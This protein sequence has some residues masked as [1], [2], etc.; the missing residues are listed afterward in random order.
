MRGERPHRH[1]PR[2]DFHQQVPRRRHATPESVLLQTVTG[3]FVDDDIYYDLLDEAD[4]DMVCK[5][6]PNAIFLVPWALEPTAMVIHDTFDKVNPIE[7]SLRNV[8]KRVLALR[9]H[10]GRLEPGGGAGD[11]V[12][13]DQAQQRPDFPLEAPWAV[14]AARKAA[15]RASPSMPPTNSTRCSRTSTTGAIILR[16][17]KQAHSVRSP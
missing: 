4:I 16:P 15:A 1:R 3:D 12:L 17:P 7:L 14:R 5:P 6:D 11:G 10:Q 8:L 13:P 2:Q 9:F